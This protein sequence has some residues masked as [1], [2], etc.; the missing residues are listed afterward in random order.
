M[1]LTPLFSE[2]V[3]LYYNM[4]FYYIVYGTCSGPEAETA[5]SQSGVKTS[6]SQGGVKTSMSQSGVKTALQWFSQVSGGKT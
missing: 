4:G 5:T 1:G 2:R 6:T 3:G